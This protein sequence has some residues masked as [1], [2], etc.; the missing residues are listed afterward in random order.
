[1]Y[2]RCLV[3]LSDTDLSTD[4]YKLL[5]AKIP[6]LLLITKIILYMQVLKI[7][8]ISFVY[9]SGEQSI[10]QCY[11]DQICICHLKRI[12]LVYLYDMPKQKMTQYFDLNLTITR[13]SRIELSGSFQCESCR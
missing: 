2:L 7:C 5:L 9:S 3:I 6:I 8:V 10:T 12:G 4:N 11:I 1:M 13:K